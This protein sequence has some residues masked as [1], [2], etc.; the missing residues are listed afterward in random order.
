MRKL[1]FKKNTSSLKK[2]SFLKKRCKKILKLQDCDFFLDY[3][4]RKCEKF[5]KIRQFFSEKL[6]FLVNLQ[7]FILLLEG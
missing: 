3:P 1:I 6:D 4:Q 7:E 5:P 2:H